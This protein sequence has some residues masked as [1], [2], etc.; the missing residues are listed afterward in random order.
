LAAG[1]LGCF[2]YTGCRFS[3]V[4]AEE[5]NG[6]DESTSSIITVPDDMNSIQ[7]AIDSLPEAGGTIYIKPGIHLITQA[8]HVNRSHITIAGERGTVLKLG[9]G[10]NQPVLLIGSDDETPTQCI[11]NI[12]I[13]NFGIDGNRKAQSS[14]TDPTRPWLRNNGI[15]V[16]M[17]SD[18]WINHV[19]IFDARSGGI[20]V[21][22][23]S[24]RIFIDT[25]SFHD[26]FFDGI[27]LYASQDIQVTNFN[28]YDNNAAGISLDNRLQHVLFSNGIIKNNDSSGLFVRDSTDVSFFNLMVVANG[29]NDGVNFEDGCYLSHSADSSDNITGVTRLFF[30]SC[31]FIK[32]KRN[33]IYL[34]SPVSQS[35]KNAV[36]GCLFSENGGEAVKMLGGSAL[37]LASNIFQ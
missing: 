6:D 26:N 2:W 27:A 5:K 23:D 24:K 15:D 18:L 29:H 19:D 35:A 8:I 32:N 30:N 17:V 16:R 1:L 13:K 34:D 14:E 37:S 31:S 10:V 21:S 9:D 25:S 12:Q 4:A 7:L 33:G 3:S 28:S 11:K 22:W 20:V 36:V